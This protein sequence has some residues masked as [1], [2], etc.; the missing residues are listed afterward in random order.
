MYCPACGAQLTQALSYCNR[1]GAN[2]T[3]TKDQ[4]GGAAESTTDTLVWVIVGTTITLL[5]MALGALVLM[6]NGSIDRGLG[7]PF[8]ILSF[9]ALVLVEGVLVWRLLSSNRGMQERS[10]LIQS[11]DLST[12][13]LAPDTASDFHALPEPAPGVTEQTTRT[14]V[15]SERKGA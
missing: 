12:E 14:L 4:G 3:T 11:K 5:G 1:C 7:I 15:P 8:V 2:L 6:N 9:G 13:K 10:A